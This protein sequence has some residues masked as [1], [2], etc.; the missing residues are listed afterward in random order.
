MRPQFDG[1]IKPDSVSQSATYD[2]NEAQHGAHH[3]VDGDLA[4]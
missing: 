1:E 2:G 3:A 4:T